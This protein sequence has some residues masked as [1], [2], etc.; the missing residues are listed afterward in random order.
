VVEPDATG[1]A[2]I[3]RINSAIH[4]LQALRERLRCKDLGVPGAQRY[5]TPAE[6]LPSDCPEARDTYS[7]ALA[8]LLDLDTCMTRRQ[9]Q[10]HQAL[11]PLDTD[12]PQTPG[13]KI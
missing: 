3:H 11:Q 7:Q 10:M 9:H 5:R 6:D 8:Q 1:H 12:M 4:V 2:R 13:V